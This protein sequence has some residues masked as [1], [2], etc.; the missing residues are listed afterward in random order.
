MRFSQF[1]PVGFC[2]DWL[3]DWLIDW[4]TERLVDWL[5]DWLIDWFY[6]LIWWITMMD[7][8]WSMVDYDN[9]LLLIH[10]WLWWW[11]WFILMDYDGLWLIL[12]DQDWLSWFVVDFDWLWLIMIDYDCLWLIAWLIPDWF[13][14]IVGALSAGFAWTPSL[15]DLHGRSMDYDWL[16]LIIVMDYDGLWLILMDYGWL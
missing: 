5:I 10:A 6:S 12:M 7:Y 9:R 4:L 16:W 1:C 14:L 11:K 13:W 2:T 3:I 8:G 15:R